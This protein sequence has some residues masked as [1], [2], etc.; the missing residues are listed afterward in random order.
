MQTTSIQPV[1]TKN[2]HNLDIVIVIVIVKQ[3]HPLRPCGPTKQPLTY[4]LLAYIFM[5]S[6]MPSAVTV[7][8]PVFLLELV[9]SL[10]IEVGHVTSDR[11][12]YRVKGQV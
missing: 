9:M 3:N 2:K 8:N 5:C 12:K 7:L 6:H 10:D 1:M 4:L 11:S